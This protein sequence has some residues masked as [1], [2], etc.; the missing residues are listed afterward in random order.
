MLAGEIT[1]VAG[2]N[3]V[4]V[5]AAFHVDQIGSRYGLCERGENSLSR[6]QTAI[7]LIG[8]VLRAVLDAVPAVGAFLGDVPGPLSHTNLKVADVPVTR[9]HL[10]QGH[11]FDVRVPAHLGHF[12]SQDADGAV[13]GGKGLVDLGHPAADARILFHEINLVARIGQIQGGL[14][15]GHASTHHQC[16]ANDPDLGFNLGFQKLGP[17]HG[18]LHEVLCLFRGGLPVVQMDPTAVFPDVGHLEKV[19]VQSALGAR[20]TERGF[21][22]PGCAGGHHNPVESALTDIGLDLLLT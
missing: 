1:L 6:G 5:E 13:H 3:A 8:H 17:L 9:L 18:H 15:T 22:E 4:L 19:R 11:Q 2:N 16:L 21:V 20:C 12:G 7:E 14:D 10:A